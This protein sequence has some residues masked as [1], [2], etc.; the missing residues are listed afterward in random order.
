MVHGFATV[1]LCGAKS[2][3][4]EGASKTRVADEV[5][6]VVKEGTPAALDTRSKDVTALQHLGPISNPGIRSGRR[7]PDVR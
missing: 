5:A 3:P 1:V 4:R 6:A 2:C 7:D